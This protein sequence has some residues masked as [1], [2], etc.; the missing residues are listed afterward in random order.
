MLIVTHDRELARVADRVIIIGFDG[1]TQ[2]CPVLFSTA[3]VAMTRDPAS[4]QLVRRSHFSVRSPEDLP[5]GFSS[6]SGARAILGR[7][8]DGP[9]SP[10]VFHASSSQ[11]TD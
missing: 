6:A 7:V 10:Y 8:T 11:V 4:Q 9:A 3:D 1:A 5:E 2:R